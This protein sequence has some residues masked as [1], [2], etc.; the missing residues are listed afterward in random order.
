MLALDQ[1][2]YGVP[3]SLPAVVVMVLDLLKE[4]TELAE[5]LVAD[6]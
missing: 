6:E 4:E 2:G 3:C 1:I 5:V